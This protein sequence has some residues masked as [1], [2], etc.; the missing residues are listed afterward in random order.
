MP[1]CPTSSPDSNHHISTLCFY[2]SDFFL[3]STCKE[4]MQYLS[5]SVRLTSLSLM[6]SRF[7]CVVANGRIK[8]FLRLYNIPC[9][10]IS[11]GIFSFSRKEILCLTAP[12]GQLMVSL[13]STGVW[14]PPKEGIPESFSDILD[15]SIPSIQLCS[16][17]ETSPVFSLQNVSEYFLLFY[18]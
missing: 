10:F 6:F 16:T 9:I 7:L 12:L 13:K 2:E 4:I 3:G 5:F 8:L 1:F 18:I 15:L 14:T 17:K 11:F